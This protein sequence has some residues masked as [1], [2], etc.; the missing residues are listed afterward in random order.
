MMLCEI[1]GNYS[2]YCG[3]EYVGHVNAANDNT[4][5]IISKNIDEYDLENIF[6]PD[7]LM[8]CIRQQH[9]CFSVFTDYGLFR[10]VTREKYRNI[11][12][13]LYAYKKYA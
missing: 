8:E 6:D 5:G 1:I 9:E 11:Y 7:K 12:D 13:C 10:F 4:L 2:V 3:D